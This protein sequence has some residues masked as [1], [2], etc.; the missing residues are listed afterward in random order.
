M[1]K[2]HLLSMQG[3]L[4]RYLAYHYQLS[5]I[6]VEA[7]SCHLKTALIYDKYNDSVMLCNCVPRQI[8][9]DIQ[10]T[11]KN[12]ETKKGNISYIEQMACLALFVLLNFKI[13]ST[14]RA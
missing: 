3:H 12:D 1:Q 13:F 7:V 6:A 11:L 5:V 9:A 10:K 4:S 14:D 8:T 2:Y